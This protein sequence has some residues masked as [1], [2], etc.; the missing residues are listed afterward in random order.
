MVATT[1]SRIRLMNRAAATDAITAPPARQA[2]NIAAVPPALSSC[3]NATLTRI[4]SRVPMITSPI[5]RYPIVRR[6]LG[7]ANT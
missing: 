1:P 3:S 7:V 4:T 2:L 6:T 5:V